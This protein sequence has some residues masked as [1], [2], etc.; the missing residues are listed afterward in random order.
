[1]VRLVERVRGKK[2]V[3]DS[4]NHAC[5]RAT[6]RILEECTELALAF[7]M[8][9]ADIMMHVV[10]ALANEA[11][12]Q[13]NETGKYTFPSEIFCDCYGQAQE[14]ADVMLWLD[15]LIE[16]A[17]FKKKHIVEKAN[18]K[19]ESLLKAEQHGHLV[20]VDDCLYKG[21]GSGY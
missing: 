2:F 9:P 3:A 21:I 20:V 1:M 11:R 18:E 5:Q 8:K 19:Y 15:Y 12:K 14:L 6:G 4:L 17:V 16:L 10:D 13:G 7:N